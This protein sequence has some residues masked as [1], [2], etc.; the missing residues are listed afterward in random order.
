MRPRGTARGLLAAAIALLVTAAV[1]FA[2]TE[3][4]KTDDSGWKGWEIEGYGE[5]GLRFLPEDPNHKKDAKFEEYRDINQ[6]LYLEDLRIRLYRPDEKYSVEISGK[7]WGLQTQ[8]FHLLGEQLGVWQAGFDWDQMRHIYSTTARTLETEVSEGVWKLPASRPTLPFWNN[9]A[10]G[11]GDVGVRWDT[12]HVFFKTSPTQEL[13]VLADYTRIHKDGERPQGMAFGSPG[14]IFLQILEPINQTIHDFRLRTSWVTEQWQ[15]Q[16]G[17]T[18]SLFVE[19]DP[20]LRADNPCNPISSVPPASSFGACPAVGTTAQFGTMSLPPSN[21]AHTVSLSGG[22]NLPM[23][24]RLN[25]NASYSLRFQDDPF[26]QQ[27]YSNSLSLSTPS[28][29]LAAKSLGGDVQIG[30]LNLTLTSRPLPAPVTFTTKYRLYSFNDW[31]R[32]PSFEGYLLNDQSTVTSPGPGPEPF[33]SVRESYTKQNAD[34]DARWKLAESLALTVGT[35]WEEWKRSYV[36]EVPTSDEFFA[37]AAVDITPNDWLLI[38]ATYTPSFRRISQY[39]TNA[40]REAENNAPPGEGNGG[41]TTAPVQSYLL[42]KFDESDRDSQRAELMVQV[43]PLEGLAFT[44]SFNYRWDKYLDPGFTMGNMLGLQN[45]VTWSAG[46]DATWTPSKRLSLET[47]Y[48]YESNFQKM[49]SRNRYITAPGIGD[50]PA[51]NWISDMTDTVQT[52]HLSAKAALIPDKLDLKLTANYSYALGTVE[53][54]NP[55]LAGANNISPAVNGN[56][57]AQRFPAYTDSLLRL[58]AA[59]MYRLTKNLT[60]KLYYIYETYNQHDWQTDTLNPFLP[61]VPSIYLGSNTNNYAAQIVGATLRYKF[62]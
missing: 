49:Q 30:L 52:V 56:T 43:T 31:S 60:A 47:G 40:Q 38:R 34:L 16:F 26:L 5:A 33:R 22:V 39:Q 41:S 23:R 18:L 54:R 32:Q 27:T 1:A 42:R 9:A 46:M 29:R 3:P 13:D 19:N 24:T 48:M 28:V 14:G 35:S 45:Q 7:D 62:E 6:G 36:R 58:E 10:G 59:L 4:A 55:N 53:T 11:L 20:F 8:E 12:A 61:G 21:Q 57:L 2:Q 50:T 17:Y 15:L 25:A 44:P 37:K 51:A